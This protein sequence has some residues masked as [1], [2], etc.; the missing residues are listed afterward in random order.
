MIDEKKNVIIAK[1]LLSK[2]L[3]LK[4]ATI[5]REESVAH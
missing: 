2:Q 4:F 5:Y 1:C 3:E